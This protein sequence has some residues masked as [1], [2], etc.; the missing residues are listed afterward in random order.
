MSPQSGQGGPDLIA[1]VKALEL[2]MYTMTIH[3]LRQKKIEKIAISYMSTTDTVKKVCKNKAR[4]RC[5][6]YCALLKT[7]LSKARLLTSHIEQPSKKK[8]FHK[9]KVIIFIATPCS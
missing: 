1:C 7:T 9:N 4:K 8:R 5:S 6:A 2:A 3:L